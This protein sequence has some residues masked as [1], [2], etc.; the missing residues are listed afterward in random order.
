MAFEFEEYTSVVKQRRRDS[1]R[2]RYPSEVFRRDIRDEHQPHVPPYI[3]FT[4]ALVIAT[5]KTNPH[6]SLQRVSSL[7]P[8]SSCTGTAIT[9]A[10]QQGRPHLPARDD[11]KQ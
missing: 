6:T 10:P 9:R 7:S 5:K 1:A 8:P 3:R 4:P 11:R 2:V